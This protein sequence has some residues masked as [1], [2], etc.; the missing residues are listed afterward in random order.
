[1]WYI[2]DFMNKT[3]KENAME[4]KALFDGVRF[5][6]RAEEIALR[7]GVACQLKT[8]LGPPESPCGM[9]LVFGAPDET[10]LRRLWTEAGIGFRI[11][12]E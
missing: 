11:E 9:K 5:L 10:L 6:M 3:A 2:L 1:M 8:V 4:R 12:N 7:Q